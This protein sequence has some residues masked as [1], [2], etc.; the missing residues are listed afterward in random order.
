METTSSTTAPGS[1]SGD[2]T[3]RTAGESSSSSGVVMG[4]GDGE[5]DAGEQCDGD[6]L[7][8]FDCASLGLGGGDLFCDPITCTFDTSM[9]GPVGSTS[10]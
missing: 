3:T 9:C 10:G 6:D 1:S 2:A 8:G 4:C 7:Q 5:I